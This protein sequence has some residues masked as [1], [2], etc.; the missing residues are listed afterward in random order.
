VGAWWVFATITLIDSAADGT[1]WNDEARTELNKLYKKIETVTQHLKRD[2][3]K[4]IFDFLAGAKKVLNNNDIWLAKPGQEIAF[5]QFVITGVAFAILLGLFSGPVGTA[6]VGTI[7]LLG[8][9]RY[10]YEKYKIN[11]DKT[12]LHLAKDKLAEALEKLKLEISQRKSETTT[13]AERNYNIANGFMKKA[14]KALANRPSFSSQFYKPVPPALATVAS[15]E[16][17]TLG[18]GKNARLLA[19]N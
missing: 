15:R 11:N 4:D 19:N 6:V 10:G 2:E 7:V 18:K 16:M 9:A 14:E 12:N 5:A 17:D 8:C 1:S 3:N 13:P